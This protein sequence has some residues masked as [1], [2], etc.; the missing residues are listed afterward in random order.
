MTIEHYWKVVG[1]HNEVHDNNALHIPKG[2]V[3]RTAMWGI[4][5]RYRMYWDE[6]IDDIWDE[7][8][9]EQDIANSIRAKSWAVRA[10]L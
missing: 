10:A 1:H 2:F 7:R 9:Y 8:D 5:N 4:T 3:R 6:K